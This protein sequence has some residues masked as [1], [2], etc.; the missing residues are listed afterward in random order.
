MTCHFKCFYKCDK[1]NLVTNELL[2]EQ[3]QVKYSTLIGK[4]RKKENFKI[5]NINL[6]KT[7][8]RKEI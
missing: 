4:N 2:F 6:I 3:F 5:Y 8:R 1:Y 7:L